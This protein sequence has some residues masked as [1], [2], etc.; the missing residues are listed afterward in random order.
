MT[1]KCHW[2]N[3]LKA[4]SLANTKLIV[5]VDPYSINTIEELDE[6][7][8]NRN[9]ALYEKKSNP[10]IKHIDG[11]SILHRYIAL[12]QIFEIILKK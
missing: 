4:T 11:I 6:T 10:L 9:F 12:F 2:Y 5:I 3:G 7:E 1:Y 8:N